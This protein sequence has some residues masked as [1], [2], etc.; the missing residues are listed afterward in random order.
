MSTNI[1]IGMKTLYY[2]VVC[3][4][5]QLYS[6]YF[7]RLSFYF[8]LNNLHNVSATYSI[9]FAVVNRPSVNRMLDSAR[10]LPPPSAETTYDERSS[11]MHELLVEQA[12]PAASS[13]STSIS[14]SA[15]GSEIFKLFGSRS[16]I[17]PLR[18]TVPAILLFLPCPVVYF[19]C[20][21]L[22]IGR[23]SE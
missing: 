11:R 1:R 19:V 16:S 9:S 10:A 8:S 3:F 23:I 21:I 5:N 6:L 17:S 12:I 7:G 14:V 15:P 2:M 22:L 4:S 18:I 20:A 13:L